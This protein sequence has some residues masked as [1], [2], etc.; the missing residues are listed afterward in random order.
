MS[1]E[2]LTDIASLIP[3]VPFV[4]LYMV[5]GALAVFRFRSSPR[6]MTWLLCGLSAL[7]MQR[8]IEAWITVGV[9][10]DVAHSSVVSTAN[11]IRTLVYF[12][13]ALAVGGSICVV[14]AALKVEERQSMGVMPNISLERTRGE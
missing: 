3:H 14:V 8:L 4:V 12:S 1:G 9:P 2:T 6:R 11:Y 13:W 5:A 10:T 7:L